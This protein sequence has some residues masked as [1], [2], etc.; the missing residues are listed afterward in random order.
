M[1]NALKY[2]HKHIELSVDASGEKV[3][4]HVED[5]G[6]GIPEADRQ[7]VFEPFARLDD[8]RSR[9]S[10]GYGLGLAIVHRVALW[11]KGSASV[12]DSPLGDARFTIQWPGLAKI[13]PKVEKNRRKFDTY[14]AHPRQSFFPSSSSSLV[15]MVGSPHRSQGTE[16]STEAVSGSCISTG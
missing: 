3:F 1:R 11:H 13:D 2:G 8:S 10:G 5:D 4:I 7:R 15:L 16:G 6:P 14:P 9:Y 12:T